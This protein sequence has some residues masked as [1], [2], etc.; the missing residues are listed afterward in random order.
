MRRKSN[1]GKYIFILLLLVICGGGG[2]IYLSPQFEQNKPEIDFKNNFYWNLQDKPTLK[3][4]DDR[5]VKFYKV[6]FKDGNN[7]IVLYNKVLN[8]SQK[9]ISLELIAPKLDMFFKSKEIEIIVEVIDNSKWN[10]LDG[11]KTIQNFRVFIDKKRPTVEVIANSLAIRKGGSAV[12]IVKIEDENLKDAYISFSQKERFELIPFYKE[13]YYISLIAWPVTI[14]EFTQVNLIATDSANNKS[15]VKIPLYIRDLKKNTSKIKISESF[16]KNVSTK[17]IEQSSELMPANLTDIFIKE[18]REIR[19][20]NIATIKRV[21]RENMNKDM[22]ER[23]NIKPFKR[24]TNSATAG[25]YAQKRY[26]YFDNEQ[27]DEAWHL[28]IDWA[29]IK[30]APIYVSNS[31]MVIFNDYLGIYGNT[32]I[33]DHKLGLQTL[34]AHTSS[35]SVNLTDH[36][37]AKQQIGNTGTTGAVLGDH[38]HFGILVQGIEVNPLEWMDKNWIKTRITDVITEAKKAI[39]KK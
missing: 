8:K 35:S 12:A 9:N 28:G 23:F 39:S 17:V 11:N 6:I 16:I 26:Y 37:K 24:L 4:S 1:V 38:L 19:E 36:V 21:S 3:L 18:N 13:N 7:E 10:F 14:D 33:I 34:Y 30:K 20:Q 15:T 29:S 25:H 31:G 5:G 2:F 27:I 32:I 22:I